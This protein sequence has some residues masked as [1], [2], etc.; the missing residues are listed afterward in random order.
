MKSLWTHLMHGDTEQETVWQTCQPN[1]LM[2]PFARVSQ[3]WCPGRF[4]LWRCFLGFRIKTLCAHFGMPTRIFSKEARPLFFFFIQQPTQWKNSQDWT[5]MLSIP[6]F[7]LCRQQSLRSS[8]SHAF[9][10]PLHGPLVEVTWCTTDE[11]L[12]AKFCIA[13]STRG[14][15]VIWEMEDLELG[16]LYGCSVQYYLDFWSW[17][18]SSQTQDPT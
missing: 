18:K 13:S 10:S 6:S 16:S 8:F 1:Q 4:P 7:F 11:K 9:A 14:V 3:C 17:M 5:A 15:M 12:W 2:P